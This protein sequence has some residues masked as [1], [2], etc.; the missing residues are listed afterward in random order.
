MIKK[1]FKRKQLTSNNEKKEN[2]KL[3]YKSKSVLNN[4]FQNNSEIE[5]MKNPIVQNT[6]T[7]QKELDKKD[8]V[9]SEK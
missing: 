7:E 8:E 1:N 2:K 3:K 9:V 6:I 4:I 5:I